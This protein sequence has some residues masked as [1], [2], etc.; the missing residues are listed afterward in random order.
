V[1]DWARRKAAL[2]GFARWLIEEQGL[3]Q[4]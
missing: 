2:N 4:R 3:L 1:S